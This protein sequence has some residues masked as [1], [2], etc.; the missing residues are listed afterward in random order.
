LEFGGT[1]ECLFSNF[2]KILYTQKPCKAHTIN[3]KLISTMMDPLC[4][5]RADD[6]DDHRMM[7]QLPPPLPPGWAEEMDP[8]SGQTYYYNTKDA[9]QT[10]W[11]RPAAGHAVVVST[12]TPE[13]ETT[14]AYSSATTFKQQQHAQQGMHDDDD[15]SSSSRNHR[16]YYQRKT[17]A[18]ASIIVCFKKLCAVILMAPVIVVS[19][20]SPP[21]AAAHALAVEKTVYRNHDQAIQAHRR[22]LT[23]RIQK[24]KTVEEALALLQEEEEEAV[25]ASTSSSLF[26]PRH[27][28]GQYAETL[29]LCGRHKNVQ[30]ALDIVQ[31]LVPDSELCRSKAISIC[32]SCGRLDDALQLLFCTSTSAMRINDAQQQQQQQQQQPRVYQTAS[33]YNAAIAACGAQKDWEAA[34][35]V[36]SEIP[37]HLLSNVAINAVLMGL[38]KARRGGEALDLLNQAEREWGIKPTRCGLH[39]TL[40]ALLAD[41]KV[42]EAC[43]LV[44]RMQQESDTSLHPNEETYRRLTS[45]VSGK[46]QA[47]Q[48]VER[49]LTNDVKRGCLN[50]SFE[51]WK[52]E[53]KVGHG[54]DSFWKIGTVSLLGSDDGDPMT[55]VVGLQPNRN[56]ATN[57]MKLVFYDS[58]LSSTSSSKSADERTSLSKSRLG[59]LLMINS[60]KDRTSTLLG[61]FVKPDLRGQG[62]AKILLAVWFKL[63]LDADVRALT[64]R[65]QKPLL[66]LVL[67]HTF[68]MI[69]KSGGVQAELSPGAAPNAVVL[70]SSAV[71]LEGALSPLD[72]RNQSIRLSVAPA[73]PRGRP[74]TVG[75][76]FEPPFNL[77]KHVDAVLQRRWKLDDEI[78]ITGENND[79][80]R[81][82]LGAATVETD[83][84]S[85]D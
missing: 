19:F 17:A 81:I 52:K 74:I 49:L 6:D 51:P 54:K 48:I 35:F 83:T 15:N 64:G 39:N 5:R 78:A 7:L 73:H 79:L 58:S 85:R 55:V 46:P 42:Q 67:Q 72:L 30:V 45:A 43:E 40:S 22:L 20:L 2:E 57:G 65:I 75:C 23:V 13:K 38:V 68:G 59:Y 25:Q 18:T 27:Y 3:D 32:G 37:R 34:L 50:C 82:L 4:Q 1:E 44:L 33:P 24:C 61:Q 14:K 53:I 47:L 10:T 84:A 69:P 76:T 56:P 11:S 62:M 12:R 66:S 26:D 70:Y 21:S 8:A 31:R 77:Q 60:L 63:C 9:T 36:L 71:S 80:R 28:E 41:E 29:N 16:S